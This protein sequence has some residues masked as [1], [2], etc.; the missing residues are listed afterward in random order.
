[1]EDIQIMVLANQSGINVTNTI[2]PIFVKKTSAFYF[3]S[4][5]FNSFIKCT[6]FLQKKVLR[7]SITLNPSLPK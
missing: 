4:E 3:T 7:T 2:K 6:S 5:I 1:M